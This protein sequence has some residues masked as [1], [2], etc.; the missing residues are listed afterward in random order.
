ML[1]EIFFCFHYFICLSKILLQI[2]KYCNLLLI[3]DK[4]FSKMA[5]KKKK[6][7]EKIQTC[8]MIPYFCSLGEKIQKILSRKKNYFI[9]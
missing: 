1:K 9:Y 4:E 2:I 5:K 6:K 3:I 8:P 7:S